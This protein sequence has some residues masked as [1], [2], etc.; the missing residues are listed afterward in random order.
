[1]RSEGL[2]RIEATEDAQDEWV[3]H[4]AE[5]AQESLMSKGNSWYVGANIPGKPRVVMPY[6]GGQPMYQDRCQEVAEKGYE[7]FVLS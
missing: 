1:M 3:E 7:G 5:V 2:T 6:C 4:V